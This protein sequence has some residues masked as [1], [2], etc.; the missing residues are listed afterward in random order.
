MLQ[1]FTDGLPFGMYKT[2]YEGSNVPQT[3]QGWR[4]VAINQQKKFVHMK[5]R[6][7]MFKT[8]K[9]KAPAT[10]PKWGNTCNF[11]QKPLDPN[12]MDTSPGRIKGCVAEVG[13]FMLGGPRW[14]Q[15][16]NNPANRPNKFQPAK[17]R[18]GICYCCGN[19]GHITCN[20]PQKPPPNMCGPWV[21]QNQQ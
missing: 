4:G 21:S 19:V 13:D 18:E 10:K 3:Y 9:P 8:Q 1:K 7:D 5:G 16:V 2:I 6:L 17:L 15:S 14:H 12:A 20:C 11:Y